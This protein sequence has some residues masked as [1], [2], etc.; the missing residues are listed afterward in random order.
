MLVE[1]TSLL[2]LRLKILSLSATSV[3]R[4]SKLFCVSTLSPKSHNITW[5]GSGDTCVHSG[6]YYQGEILSLEKTSVM[7]N[8]HFCFSL[9]WET[10]SLSPKT[11]CYTNIL[12]VI[13]QNQGTLCL[14]DM[15]SHETYGELSS[16]QRTIGLGFL[17]WNK[18][19]QNKQ[20]DQW[21]RNKFFPI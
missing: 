4:V 18:L 3:A 6:L 20:A 17:L 1:E 12:E 9:C 8:K 15:Q 5:K 2:G 10:L 7:V 16:I 21:G 14:E 19:L 11:V 13:V